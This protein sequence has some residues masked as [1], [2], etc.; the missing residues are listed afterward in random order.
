MTDDEYNLGRPLGYRHIRKRLSQ[1]SAVRGCET[2]DVC[3][4][5]GMRSAHCQRL[6]RAGWFGQDITTT[7]TDK[8]SINFAPPQ[9]GSNF[10]EEETD[11]GPAPAILAEQII[12]SRT[13][14]PNLEIDGIY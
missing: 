1:L 10:F 6:E 5:R 12:S 13:S 3:T 2:D 9:A 8:E 4:P 7:N 11:F 14:V